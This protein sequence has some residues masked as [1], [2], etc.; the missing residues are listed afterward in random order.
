MMTGTHDRDTRMNREQPEEC[1]KYMKKHR[2]Y[3]VDLCLKS[4]GILCPFNVDRNS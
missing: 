4:C 1:L 3:L 2:L